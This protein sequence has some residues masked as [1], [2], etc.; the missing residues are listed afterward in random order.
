M[1]RCD[2]AVLRIELDEVS[3]ERNKA[4]QVANAQSRIVKVT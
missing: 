2:T 1:V 4:S 3:T